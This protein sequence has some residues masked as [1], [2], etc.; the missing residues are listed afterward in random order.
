MAQHRRTSEA[1]QVELTDAAL[2]IIATRGIAALS[3]RA[4]AEHVG[5]SSGA[6]FRHFASLDALLEA[7]VS[8]VESVLEA[9]YPPADLP[10]RGRL[11][12]FIEA[13]SAAVGQHTGIPQLVLSPQFHLALPE[14]ASARLS[15]CVNKTRAFVRACIREGQE[16]GDLRADIDPDA[17]ALVVMGSIQMLA[18]STAKP[19]KRA[20]EVRAVRSALVALLEPS[21][22]VPSKRKRSSS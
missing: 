4:L 9:T 8:R 6:I 21:A 10:A 3:T 5:L 7:L 11:E 16:V 1:R 18:L 13:R 14:R 12:R 20:A 22:P 17:L 19:R 15:A 2:H